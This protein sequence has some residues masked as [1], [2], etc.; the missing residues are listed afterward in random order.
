M[1]CTNKILTFITM[2]SIRESSGRKENDKSNNIIIIII[3]I[4]IYIIIV[5]RL[6]LTF[7]YAC[8]I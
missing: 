4:L 5:R 7:M 2:I 1:H 3:V 6:G 8:H